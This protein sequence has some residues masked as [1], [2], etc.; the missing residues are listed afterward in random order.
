MPQIV[1]T[2]F[3]ATFDGYIHTICLVP[4]KIEKNVTQQKGVLICIKDVIKEPVI[5]ENPD[6]RKK[7]ASSIIDVANHNLNI[8][9]LN[10]YEAVV[11]MIDFVEEHG[12]TIVSHNFLSDI[13][14]LVKTQDFIGGKRIIKKRL[15]EYPDTGMYDKRWENISKI[16]SMCLLNNRCPNFLK[17]FYDFYKSNDICSTPSG[18]YSTKLETF[19]QFVKNDP[20]YHQSHS[21]VQDTIDLVNVLKSAATLDGKGIIDGSSYIVKPEWRRAVL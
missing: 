9:Y 11:F 4:V 1:V 5:Q 3:E 8:K 2:D 20:A 10:F 19:T 18:Y 13:G 12:G 16:C 6:V 21:A 7:I 17:K 15:K 14:F